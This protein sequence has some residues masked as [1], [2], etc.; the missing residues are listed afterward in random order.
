MSTKGQ[1]EKPFVGEGRRGSHEQGN[2]RDVI[3]VFLKTRQL[4]FIPDSD[5]TWAAADFVRAPNNLQFHYYG[6]PTIQEKQ[7]K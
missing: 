2:G 5:H 1:L 3:Q 7:E 4:T 6:M